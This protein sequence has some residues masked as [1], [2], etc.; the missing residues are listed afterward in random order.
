MVEPG[1]AKIFGLA[2]MKGKGWREPGEPGEG[3][4]ALASASGG[5]SFVLQILSQASRRKM[6]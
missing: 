5:R 1:G 6:Q 4:V 2:E 3:D